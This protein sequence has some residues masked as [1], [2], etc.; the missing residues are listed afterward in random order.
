ME[1]PANRYGVCPPNLW[2][3]DATTAAT[4]F[5]SV[6][7]T[8]PGH[9]FTTDPR[10]ITLIVTDN[11]AFSSSNDAEPVKYFAGFY[12]TGWDT[13]NGNGKPKGCYGNNPPGINQ[14]GAPNNDA[15][16]LL[17]CL[18]GQT[19]K[20]DNGDVWGHFVKTVVF[21]ASATPSD[22]LCDLTSSS[23]ETCVAVLVE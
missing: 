23:P 16:P 21:S 3:T 12:V 8:P 5:N 19:V 22:D 7:A 14:C 15:H 4:F 18:A 13:D 1:D 9:D 6:D 20:S 2:P 11:T 10:Y 17:G